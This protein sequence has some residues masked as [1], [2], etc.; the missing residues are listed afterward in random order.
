VNI[1]LMP[2]DD[3]KTGKRLLYWGWDSSPIMV[4]EL[5]EDRVSFAPGQA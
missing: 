3:P 1:D 5:T 4:Q 2:F